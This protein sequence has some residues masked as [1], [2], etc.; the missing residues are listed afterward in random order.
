MISPS[1]IKAFLNRR[2]R[3]SNL[4][5]QLSERQ[6]DARINALAPPPHWKTQPRYLHQKVSFLLALKHKRYCIWADPGLGKSWIALAVLRYA[7]RLHQNNLG[8]KPRAL[9]LVPGTSNL[10]QWVDEIRI[11]APY[12]SSQPVDAT[13]AANRMLQVNGDADVVILTYAG[14]LG[15]VCSG[16]VV[17][18]EDGGA[19]LD[20]EGNPET[21]GWVLDKKKL[22]KFSKRFNFFI[23]DESHAFRTKAS[24]TT[25]ACRTLAWGCEWAY[26]MTGTPHGMD[27]IDMWSQFYVIDRGETLGP[28]MGLFREALYTK[29]EDFWAGFRFEFNKKNKHALNRMIRHGSI[30][31]RDTE[32]A[33]LPPVI[34]IVRPVTFSKELFP[35]YDRLAE[36]LRNARGDYSEVENS[37]MRLR[38]ICG[39]YLSAKGSNGDTLEI[40]FKVNPKLDALMELLA[41]IPADKKVVI[42]HEFKISGGLIS[43]ALKKAKIKH[44]WLYSG[45]KREVKLNIAER[46]ADPKIRVLL[47]SSA[48]AFGGNWQISHHFIWFERPCDPIIWS[49]E[50]KRGDRIGQKN[51]VFLYDLAVVGSVDERIMAAHKANANLFAAVVDG[52]ADLRRDKRNQTQR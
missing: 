31:Y 26:A 49:Q 12:Y 27:P 3:D 47:S 51:T 37:F 39:G 21:K 5:K 20:A 44:L 10:G 16:K 36:E 8:N 33:D 6:I 14:F 34:P 15:L 29:T 11:H 40:R 46:F 22:N 30:R 50:K 24:L 25:R 38:Q 1:A 4:A 23:G 42:F 52:K 35:Y 17:E 28:T 7:H 2:L 48:G 32:C 19:R 43:A 18:D 45:T 41:E 9:V 13:G